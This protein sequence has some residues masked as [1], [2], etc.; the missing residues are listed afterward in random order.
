MALGILSLGLW[1]ADLETK[2][3]VVMAAEAQPA[4]DRH[5]RYRH[6]KMERDQT[7]RE[8]SD[9]VITIKKRSYASMVDGLEIAVYIL[10]PLDLRGARGHAALVWLHGG[11]RGDLD[12]M[13]FPFIKEAVDRGYVVV[14]PEY[15]GS[16]G[17]GRE[18]YEAID[19]GGY[20]T[21]DCLTAVRYMTAQMPY[22]DPDRLGIIGLSHG[23][24]VA[25]HSVFRDQTPFKAAAALVRVTNLVFRL[26]YKGPT[27]AKN[28]VAQQRID[29]PVHERR[30]V[31]IER[32]PLYHVDRLQIPLL[33][34][35]ADN[36]HDVN[37]EEAQQLIHELEY[38]KPSLAETR[39]YI[40]PPIDEFGNGH[41]FNRRVD[42][43]LSACRHQRAAR[44]VEPNLDVS[45]VAPRAVPGPQH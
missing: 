24:F 14:A 41:T 42:R 29:G 32:S 36:D 35:I 9:G 27:Y 7:F 31:Y 1:F 21:E 38:Q 44:L 25:L 28:F 15:R 13:Y 18:H 40:D 22:V 30:D 17:S 11:V 33:A 2:A 43:R 37:F 4:N 16:T 23:G 5:Q 8:L 20:E 34:H 39:I 3:A 10:E 12:P 45:R 26:S 6:R 19:Y